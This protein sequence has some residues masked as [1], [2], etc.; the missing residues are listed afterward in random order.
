MTATRRLTAILAA[1][2]AGYSRLM[3]ANEEGTHERLKAHLRELVNP[4]IKEYSGRIVKNTGDGFLA[5]F[6]SVV[7]AVRCAVEI[8]R[9][10]SDR[11]ADTP[12]EKR[13]TFRI[14]I[15]LG[16]VIA[17]PDDIYGDGV[18]VAARL[19]ALADPG[20]ICVS[21]V[22][23]DQIRDKLPYPFEDKGEQIVKNI[24]RP[25]RVY[26]L[27][28]EAIAELPVSGVSVGGAPQ[29]RRATPL[30]VA[31]AVATTLVIAVIAWWVWP[32]TRS[33]PTLMN[34]VGLATERSQSALSA[35]EPAVAPRL[36]I[37]VLPFANLSNDP[38]QQYF[39]DGI[40]EDLTTDLS[41]VAD[42]LVISRNTAFTYRNKPLDTKQIGREL[43]VRYL[44]EGSVRRSGNQVRVNAQ[45]IDAETDAHL[46]A[47]RFDHDTGD[48]FALQNEITSRIAVALNAEVLAAEVARAT[49]RN[50]DALAYILQGRAAL[51][52]PPGLD[53]YGEAINSFE[54]ALALDPQSIEAKGRLAN[55]LVDC[56]LDLHPRSSWSDLKRADALANE[57]LAALPGSTPAHLAKGQLLRVEGRCDEA[58][59]EFEIVIASNRNSS[60]ALFALG[61][62][63]LL[64]GSIDEAIPL[65]EQAIRLGPRD[66]YV[67][68]RYLVIGKVH[69]LQSRIDEAIVW[70]ERARIGN[71]GSPW[72]HLWL[73]AAYA[74]NDQS[75]RATAELAETRE[76]LGEGSF[77]SIAQMKAHGYWGV[78]KIDDLFEA[79]YFAGLRKAGVPEE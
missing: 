38:E 3:G 74:L 26:A 18:N 70:L 68:N 53:S 62:C 75:D 8:Q 28:P 6:S 37:V 52:Q 10:M 55:A 78:P 14:G 67:F 12:E 25:V 32:V 76:R 15:N 33:S 16:D 61:E 54:H 44:L 1:D 35:P 22:V 45:L 71:P 47:D 56:V 31:A 19:E 29:R 23:R 57:A 48:L 7:V 11:N 43:G 5:E 27:H 42:M 21:R 51:A 66:P 64:T 4:K 77:P 69:F 9:A 72:P 63:K 65:E 46:W 17:E 60:G 73:A 79:T 24:P 34:A 36:S 41:R 13:I 30:A 39:A 49:E 50:P 59:P 20:G 2:V 58:I 40:T